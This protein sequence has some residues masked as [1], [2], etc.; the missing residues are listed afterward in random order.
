MVY[1]FFSCYAGIPIRLFPGC[2]TAIV[3]G[4]KFAVISLLYSEKST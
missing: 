4:L 1:L 3:R 2:F